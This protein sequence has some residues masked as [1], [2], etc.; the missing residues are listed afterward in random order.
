M[1]LGN[2]TT[3]SARGHW[4]ARTEF[5]VGA[6]PHVAL[7][8]M[9]G[10]HEIYRVEDGL[11]VFLGYSP[12]YSGGGTVG[13]FRAEVGRA[14]LCNVDAFGWCLY[15]ESRGMTLKATYPKDGTP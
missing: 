2:K 10:K 12:G 3:T 7:F 6:L 1:G 14:V 11:E 5:T 9:R 13:S 15:R 8:T 4:L